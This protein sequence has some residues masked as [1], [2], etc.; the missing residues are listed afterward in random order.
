MG[1]IETPHCT[2]FKQPS[3]QNRISEDSKQ[4]TVLISKR[5]FEGTFPSVDL[6]N[7]GSGHLKVM[8]EVFIDSNRLG[9]FLGIMNEL[10]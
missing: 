4:R 8:G 6:S 2:S 9:Y 5:S 3:N 7:L 10:K 1:S